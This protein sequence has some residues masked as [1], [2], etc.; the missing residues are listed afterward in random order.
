MRSAIVHETVTGTYEHAREVTGMK[1]RYETL[2][3]TIIQDPF[4]KM[5]LTELV[6]M[7]LMAFLDAMILIGLLIGRGDQETGMPLRF[8][9]DRREDYHSFSHLSLALNR[10]KHLKGLFSHL[11]RWG[12]IGEGIMTGDGTFTSDGKRSLRLLAASWGWISSIFHS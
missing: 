6:S 2:N 12:D 7:L 1:P 8:L 9:Q 10:I 5:M 11:E 3:G 4:S